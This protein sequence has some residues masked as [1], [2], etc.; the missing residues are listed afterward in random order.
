MIRNFQKYQRP[1]RP[2]RSGV[3]PDELVSYARGD[4][5]GSDQVGDEFGI[6][7]EPVPP[8]EED[9][10]GRGEE[11]G[12]GGG[13]GAPAREPAA[14]ISASPDRKGSDEIGP[15]LRSLVGTEPVI[16]DLRTQ[17]IEE[18][19]VEGLTPADVEAGIAAAM[20]DRDFRPR[21]WKSLVGWIRR[22]AKDR[23]EA[24]PKSR[25]LAGK[26]TSRAGPTPEMIRRQQIHLAAEHFRGH[27]SD[28]WPSQCRPG[29]PDCTTPDELIDEGRLVV[30]LEKLPDPNIGQRLG[31]TH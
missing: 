1:K 21:S 20:A 16:Q 15:W 23:L 22:A 31:F 28:A 2:N 13:A 25:P 19:L 26:S 14:P 5:N 12:G 29:H 7:G 9:G 6:S 11:D 8:G 30:E 24:S 10:G 27:W 18:L 17:P 4:G 3:L